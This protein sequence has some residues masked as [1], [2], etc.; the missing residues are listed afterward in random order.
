ME[1][2][3][4]ELWNRETVPKVM[5]I[6]STRLPQRDLINL[7]LLSPWINRNLIS[8]PSLW[9]VLSASSFFVALQRLWKPPFSL[10]VGNF[11]NGLMI[12]FCFYPI[13]CVCVCEG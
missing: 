9:L 6:V 3:T 8:H 1:A 2:E 5:N 10:K 4:V 7:L 13:P 11:Y 12:F